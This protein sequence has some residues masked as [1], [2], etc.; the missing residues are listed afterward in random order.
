MACSPT[1]QRAGDADG[2]GFHTGV[3]VQVMDGAGRV[4]YAEQSAVLQGNKVLDLSALSSG[5][6]NVMLSDERG[7]SV[8][9]YIQLTQFGDFED[10]RQFVK[11]GISPGLFL[12]HFSVV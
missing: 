3:T 11:A 10:I 2:C 8:A 9:L 4:V 5:T 7:V 1:R 12:P 6:Y